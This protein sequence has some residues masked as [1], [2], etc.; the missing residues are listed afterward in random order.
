MKPVLLDTHIWIWLSIGDME[1][2]SEMAQKTIAGRTR[3]ISA[4]SC[5]ELAKLV[6]KGRL[7]FTIPTLTWI[8]R[9]LNENQIRIAD[10]TPEI[11]VASSELQGFHPD[12][13]DQIIV[14]TARVLGMPLVTADQRIIGFKGVEAIW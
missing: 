3:W 4:I 14:A 8:R 1:S 10:L 2:L 12:P 7:G 13:A 11:A 9:A 6:E 5:W